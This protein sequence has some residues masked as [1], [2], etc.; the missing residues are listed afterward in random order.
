[1]AH[2]CRDKASIR[3]GPKTLYVRMAEPTHRSKGALAG[4][5]LED[6]RVTAMSPEEYTSISEWF[7]E[8]EVPV[9]TEVD[10]ETG[11]VTFYAAAA[12]AA[13]GPRPVQVLIDAFLNLG[14]VVMS[15]EESALF[16]DWVRTN[17]VPAHR[18]VDRKLGKIVAINRGWG[19]VEGA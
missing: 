17:N 14:S 15:P 8:K 3:K 19:T 9:Q 7:A 4:T 6:G 11:R 12:D 18:Q 10:Q 1:M 2:S 13:T 5:F 16:D